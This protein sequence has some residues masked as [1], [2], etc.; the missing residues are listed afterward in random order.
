MMLKCLICRNEQEFDLLEE[1]HRE[2]VELAKIRLE[3]AAKTIVQLEEEL[4]V[5]RAKRYVVV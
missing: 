5:Y 2:E 3:N 1:K 4:S